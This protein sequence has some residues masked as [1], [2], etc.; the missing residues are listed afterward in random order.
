[1]IQ[2]LSLLCDALIVIYENNDYA[3]AREIASTIW[4]RL[5]KN[6]E[7]FV[8]DIYFVNAILYIFPIDEILHIKN[9]ILRAFE[10]YQNYPNMSSIFINVHLNL[11]LLL[12][13]HRLFKE[14]LQA[15]DMIEPLCKSKKLYFP[16]AILFIRKGICLCNLNDTN[17]G[18]ELIEKGKSYLTTLSET[19]AYDILTKEI[20]EY[21]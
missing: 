13:E 3:K 2:D 16:L 8:Y 6:N 17:I 18:D 10:K 5:A 15:I 1:M 14:A 12:I 21:K 4:N 19:A 9:F 7:H 11:S 20:E